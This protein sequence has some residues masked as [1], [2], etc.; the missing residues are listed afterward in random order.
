MVTAD[1]NIEI[2]KN[3][4]RTQLYNGIKFSGRTQ[5]KLGI[6]FFNAITAPMYATIRDKTTGEKVKIQTERLPITI[7]WYW[8]RH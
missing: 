6:G 3:P 5:K 7:F 1:P 4:A 2:M 8:T